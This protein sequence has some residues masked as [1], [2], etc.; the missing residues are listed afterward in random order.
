MKGKFFTWAS[1]TI[2]TKLFSS[3]LIHEGRTERTTHAVDEKQLK[4]ASVSFG[5]ATTLLGPY[6]TLEFAI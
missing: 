6:R 4:V 5:D 3:K 2:S 1:D